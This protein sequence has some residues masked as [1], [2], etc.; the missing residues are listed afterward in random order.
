MRRVRPWSFDRINFA[1]IKNYSFCN[2][3]RADYSSAARWPFLAKK[4]VEIDDQVV[5]LERSFWGAVDN[6]TLNSQG[7]YPSPVFE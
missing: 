3:L 4:E 5:T 6:S 7:R 2:R 1:E